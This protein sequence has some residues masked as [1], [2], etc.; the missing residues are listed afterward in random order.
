MGHLAAV[1]AF[2]IA[3]FL[4]THRPRPIAFSSKVLAVVFTHALLFLLFFVAEL[5]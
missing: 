5:P 3:P 4:F 1:H 2:G